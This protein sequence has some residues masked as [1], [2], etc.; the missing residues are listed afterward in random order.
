MD[1]YNMLKKV[2]TNDRSMLS[3]ND[4]DLSKSRD[5]ILRGLE[6]NIEKFLLSE[7]KEYMP[8]FGNEMDTE[9]D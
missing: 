7:Q 9:I 3:M 5:D 6:K 8:L 4:Y 1:V 2:N